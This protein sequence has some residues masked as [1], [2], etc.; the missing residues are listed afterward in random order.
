MLLSTEQLVV[1]VES[2]GIF[3]GKVFLIIGLVIDVMVI[4]Q[5]CSRY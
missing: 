5:F 4:T 3:I 1:T 2:Y